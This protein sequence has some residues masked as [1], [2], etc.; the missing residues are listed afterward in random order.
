MNPQELPLQ[1]IHLPGEVPWWP[2]ATGWWVLLA[3]LFVMAWVGYWLFKRYR[4]KNDRKIVIPAC[5]VARSELR[6][7][8]AS[9]NENRNDVLVAQQLSALLRRLAISLFPGENVA[10]FTGVTWWRWLDDKAVATLFEDHAGRQL[11]QA[12]YGGESFDADSLIEIVSSWMDKVCNGGA[13]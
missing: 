5:Q 8:Q 3:T 10:G 6:K 2:L 4:G 7:L 12:A 9:G 11:E 1:D 13:S